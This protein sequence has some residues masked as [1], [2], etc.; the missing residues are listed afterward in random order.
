M[1]VLAVSAICLTFLGATRASV[2]EH[3]PGVL[4]AITSDL[5]QL[6]PLIFK[7]PGSHLEGNTNPLAELL[8]PRVIEARQGACPA[9]YGQCKS[10]ANKCCPVGVWC[11]LRI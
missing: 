11:P 7:A 10:Y 2:D 9:G 3:S 6:T 8:K 4:L 5:E 1:H